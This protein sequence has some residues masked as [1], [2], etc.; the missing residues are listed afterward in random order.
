MNQSYSEKALKLIFI[1]H[2]K[3]TSSV[4]KLMK[5]QNTGG[6]IMFNISKQAI[7]PGKNFGPYG[8]PKSTTLFLNETI[9]FRMWKI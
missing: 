1:A 5:I 4:V 9:R 2:Q 3:I 6:S 8:L 7:N